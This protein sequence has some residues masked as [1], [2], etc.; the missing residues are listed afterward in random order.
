[1]RHPARFSLTVLLTAI[2]LAASTVFAGD[3]GTGALMVI[4]E[5][6]SGSVVVVDSAQDHKVL[7]RIEGLGVLHHATISFSR[8]ARYAYVVS[9]D[10]LLSK[11]DL[12]K[13]TLASQVKVGESTIGLAVSQDGK[14]I[15]VSN[16]RPGNIVMV[17]DDT[18]KI[19]KTI[20]ADKSK[21]VGLVD[22]PDNLFVVGLMDANAVWVIDAND[23]AFPVIRKYEDIGEKPYDGLLTPDG[24]FYVSGLFNSPWITMIDLWNI[25]KPT[26]VP[27][28]KLE[29][30]GK[31]KPVL[32]I[33]HLE[34]W[35]VAGDE[36]FAPVIGGS[37]LA[38]VDKKTQ[39]VS[40]TI[41]LN[42]FP[43]FSITA[44]DSRTIWVNYVMGDYHDTVD[45]IDTRSKEVVKTLK[46]G[47]GIYHMQFTP[48]GEAVYISSNGSSK[49]LVYDTRTYKLIKEIPAKKP[50]GV[51][52]SDRAHKFGL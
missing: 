9:R 50:S 12:V 43:V 3:W 30:E 21:T 45:V 32:K 48:K 41:K 22:A 25:E 39:K 4:I 13:L 28:P 35:V 40:R 34:G 31:E 46:P 24:R 44:P 1:M 47:P 51:F 14:T 29:T 7:G 19:I 2:L 10:G 15:A 16:Y 52:C 5:R 49:V 26:R 20:D 18:F 27:L 8:D 33:P 6:E 11:I 37:G 36:I 23:P 17:A 38:V 42:G